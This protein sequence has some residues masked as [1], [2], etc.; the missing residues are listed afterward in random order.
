MKERNNLT[1]WQWRRRQRS[2]FARREMN[3]LR[4]LWCGL[5]KR[6]TRGADTAEGE[7]DWS[8]VK[9]QSQLVCRRIQDPLTGPDMEAPASCAMWGAGLR[10]AGG[11][12]QAA[13]M[14]G[15]ARTVREDKGQLVR[16]C[17]AQTCRRTMHQTHAYMIS[18][19]QY[20][21]RQLERYSY[22]VLVVCDVQPNSLVATRARRGHGR[23]P[24][25][26]SRYLRRC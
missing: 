21:L 8:Q 22:R 24:E 6:V 15:T 3:Q 10:T 7:T 17:K 1:L 14:L 9:I 2:D 26:N 23:V 13:S 12:P 16:R 11:T 19:I 4:E 25:N 5:M 20:L 18:F